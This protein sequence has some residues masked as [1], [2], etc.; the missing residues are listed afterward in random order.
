MHDGDR[1][2]FNVLTKILSCYISV[3]CKDVLA[4]SAHLIILHSHGLVL[5]HRIKFLTL[6]Y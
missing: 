2:F 6:P 1:K 4:R 5:V 3:T